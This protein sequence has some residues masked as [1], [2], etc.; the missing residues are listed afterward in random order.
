M[1]R[2]LCTLNRSDCACSSAVFGINSAIHFVSLVLISVFCSPRFCKSPA[3]PRS[4]SVPVVLS[5]SFIIG[6][7]PL[8]LHDRGSRAPEPSRQNFSGLTCLCYQKLLVLFCRTLL[9]LACFTW[10]AFT[11]CQTVKIYRAFIF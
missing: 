4:F 8:W 3:S 9:T 7:R 6:L 10:T 2:P 11:D 5:L 1:R